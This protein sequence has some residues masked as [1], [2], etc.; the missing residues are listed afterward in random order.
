M[1]VCILF[2]KEMIIYMLCYV[3]YVGIVFVCSFKRLV[4]KIIIY[5]MYFVVIFVFI[6]RNWGFWEY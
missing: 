3:C 1:V 5:Y 2:Y 4:V 6:F